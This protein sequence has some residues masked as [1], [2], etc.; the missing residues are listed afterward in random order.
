M[1]DIEVQGGVNDCAGPVDKIRAVMVKQVSADFFY[2]IRGFIRAADLWF[3]FKRFFYC[4]AQL[5]FAD[6]VG[7]VKFSEEEIA[8]SQK[9]FR[10]IVRR[11]YCRICQHGRKRGA[12]GKT[13][14]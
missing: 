2:E 8:A 9:P 12:F 14:S 10:M 4:F 11:I 13:Q 5:F 1:L 6:V 7:F 3:D